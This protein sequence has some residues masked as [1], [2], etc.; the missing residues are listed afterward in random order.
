MG[1]GVVRFQP[2]R[3]EKGHSR[4]VESL[5]KATRQRGVCTQAGI[6]ASYQSGVSIQL[7]SPGGRQASCLYCAPF[8]DSKLRTST[9]T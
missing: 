8:V 2:F 3:P 5:P 6:A 4:R 7:S 1:G 9:E